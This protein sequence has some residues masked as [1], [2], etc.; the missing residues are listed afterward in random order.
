MPGIVFRE[1]KMI[2]GIISIPFFFP[3]MDDNLHWENDPQK[4]LLVLKK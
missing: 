2:R 1:G 4:E 3:Q